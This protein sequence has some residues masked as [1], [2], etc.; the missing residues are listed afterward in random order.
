VISNGTLNNYAP[1][2]HTTINYVVID[3]V[4]E[5]SNPTRA[6][7]PKLR[8][9]EAHTRRTRCVTCVVLDPSCGALLSRLARSLAR[10]SQ[11]SDV[12]CSGPGK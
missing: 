7:R 11:R 3:A 1:M 10:A 9:D 2:F 12:K 4:L 5:A 8:A 6:T